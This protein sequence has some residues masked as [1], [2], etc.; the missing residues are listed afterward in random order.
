MEGRTVFVLGAGFTRAF[1]PTAPLLIDDW[2]LSSLLEQFKGFEFA[3]S[4]LTEALA[5]GADGKI[6][7]LNG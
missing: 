2:G 1:V 4:T 5:A 6:R 3:K 7:S